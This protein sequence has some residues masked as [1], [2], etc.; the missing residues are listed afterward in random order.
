MSEYVAG[1]IM[2]IRTT[3]GMY[4]YPEMREAVP[5]LRGRKVI[6]SDLA[7]VQDATE[8]LVDTSFLIF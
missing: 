8:D 3:T 4:L 7:P 2:N 5:T 6:L 1:V